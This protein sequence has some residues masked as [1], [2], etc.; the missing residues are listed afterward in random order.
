MS[1]REFTDSSGVAW[2]VWE[3][4][5]EALSPRTKE[6]DYLAQMYI[7]GWLV[8]ETM[9]GDAKRRLYPVPLY[10]SELQNEQLESLL[11]QAAVLPQRGRDLAPT[12]EVAAP[13]PAFD[14]VTTDVTDLDVQRVFRYPGGRL[15][16][17]TML[18]AS[19]GQAGVLRFTTG[20][21]N[22]D[23]TQW[24][25]DWPDYREEQLIDLLRS[26]APRTPPTT[27]S[28]MTPRRRYNDPKA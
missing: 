16:A 11:Q 27:L 21:R 13:R 3:V 10:W 24:P 19:D 12:D 14:P 7:T 26:A 20:K 5:P 6:E 25:K 15:W 2:R 22:I 1:V 23:L 28:A 17:V 18:D 8:F 9:S 4:R